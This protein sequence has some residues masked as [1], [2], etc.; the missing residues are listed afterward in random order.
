MPTKQIHLPTKLQVTANRNRDSPTNKARTHTN[1]LTEKDEF[2]NQEMI[3]NPKVHIL[4][5]FGYFHTICH[6]LLYLHET[7]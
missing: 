4:C 2:P 1:L 7:F 6:V 3:N 5:W